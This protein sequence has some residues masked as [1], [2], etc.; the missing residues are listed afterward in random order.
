M[1]SYLCSLEFVEL[2]EVWGRNAIVFVNIFP[3]CLIEQNQPKTRLKN[4]C[5]LFRFNNQ[6]L[7]NI[8]FRVGSHVEPKK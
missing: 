6:E 7:P 5:G 2:Y 1:E 8:E 4:I 3:G